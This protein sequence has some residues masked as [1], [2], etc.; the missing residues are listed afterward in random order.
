MN[1]VFISK[2]NKT[3]LI[4]LLTILVLLW[5]VLYFIPEIFASLFTSLLGNLILVVIVLLVMMTNRLYGLIIGL[6]FIIVYRSI[7][8]STSKNIVKEGF[9]WSTKT[10]QDFLQ[11]QS[12]INPKI[13]FDVNMIQQ[14]QASQEEV[15]YFNKNA[16]WPWSE[17]T[18]QLYH[19]AIE[20]NPIIRNY[21]KDAINHTKTIYNESAI[22]RILSTQSKEGE[23]LIN[24]VLVKN[25]G[26][27]PNEDLP[28]GFGDF[29]YNSKLIGN[30]S[31]D[32]IKCSSSS[33]NSTLERITYTGK[34]G[35]FNEQT[36][37][38]TP[39]DYNNLE[40]IIPGFKF[41]DEPC[42]PCGALN[43]N[44]NYTCK[45]ELNVQ[46]KPT[47]ISKI[48]EYLWLKNDKY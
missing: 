1:N 2:G 12:T 37:T 44:A 32:V 9:D 47:G 6:L 38:V 18:T 13:I 25:P 40:S 16:E 43:V 30:L 3:K 28:S 29:G 35:I 11:I 10:T 27:N 21:S 17:E 8:L 4:G 23:F 39:V 42:N 36:Q 26:G 19:E 45:Y 15:D 20:R 5:L 41:I 46:D 48:W 33:D 31:D 22:L 14:N 34:G 24:G 7:Y